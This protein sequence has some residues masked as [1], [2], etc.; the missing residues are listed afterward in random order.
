MREMV[1]KVLNRLVE[2]GTLESVEFSEW[3]A[4]I[5]AVLKND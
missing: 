2:E 1:N 3:D 4:P 5:F